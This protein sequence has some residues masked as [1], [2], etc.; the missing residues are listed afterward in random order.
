MTDDL[1]I[2][3]LEQIDAVLMELDA[4]LTAGDIAEVRHLIDHGEPAEGVRTLA[5]ILDDKNI[6]IF[7]RMKQMI[8]DLTNGLISRE[9]M[10]ESYHE[11]TQMDDRK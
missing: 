2:R 11:K 8:L 7:P 9:D 6:Q 1:Q 4:D 5:F 3:Y 10:P